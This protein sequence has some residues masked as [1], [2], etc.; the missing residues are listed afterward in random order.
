MPLDILTCILPFEFLQVSR[1]IFKKEPPN[2]KALKNDK[3]NFDFT[4]TDKY[5]KG[6][7]HMLG[8]YKMKA[9]NG[10]GH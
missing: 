3:V 8:G 1:G 7:F 5:P 10:F 2:Q 4:H 6:T 9:E